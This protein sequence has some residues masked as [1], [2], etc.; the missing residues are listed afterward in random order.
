MSNATSILDAVKARIDVTRTE[1]LYPQYSDPYDQDAVEQ[2][3]KEFLSKL[4]RWKTLHRENTLVIGVMAEDPYSEFMGDVNNPLCEGT[5]ELVEGCI[6]NAHGNMYMPDQQLTELKLGYDDFASQVLNKL[7]QADPEIKMVHVVLSGR[8][9][10]MDTR[11][12]SVD[13]LVAAWLPGTSG[14]EAIVS[15]I[16]GEYN[17]RSEGDANKL[18][19]ERL[20]S[21]DN[22]KNY[23]IYKTRSKERPGIPDAKYPIGYG[24]ATGIGNLAEF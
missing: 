9:V 13:A 19:V 17:F 12:A 23:P 8:P 14:G 15:A 16:N 10:L 7:K 5:T 3:R 21:M 20:S 24:L 6:Y 18:P 11:E 4:S 2:E 1:L 22:L